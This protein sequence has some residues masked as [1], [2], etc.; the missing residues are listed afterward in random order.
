[1]TTF[2]T[3]CS[4]IESASVA[5]EPLGFTAQWFSEIEAFP[6]AVLHH[7]WPH[8]P[9]IGDM[10]HIAGMVR[11]GMVPAPEVF[12]AGTPCQSF[13]VAGLRE[14]IEDP[15][16]QLTLEYVRV[17]DAID[18]RRGAN[19]ECVAV[20]ENVPG[21]LTSKDNAFGEFLA[22]LCGESEGLVP[23]GKGWT[24]AGYV[25]GP[26]RAIAWRTLDAQYFGVAQRR[27]RV[28]LV[29][30]ARPDFD[31]AAVLFESEGVRRDTPPR[32]KH[33][34]AGHTPDTALRPFDMLGFGQY[35]GGLTAS[36]LKARDYKDWTDLVIERGRVRG[37]TPSERERLQGF[38]EGHTAVPYRNKPASE[39]PDGPRYKAIGNSKAVPVIRWVG[40]RIKAELT[41]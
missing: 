26:E 36:T 29:A 41:K 33:G 40:E 17:I 35:G 34:E 21:V 15:R 16:G 25:F 12:I 20:W 23:T 22:A 11:A 3:A 7:H 14:G 9:N 10:G 6:C 27:K 1:M 19:N 18:E 24:R 5:L 31:P 37:V 8:V 38:P 2:A 13:S 32:H 39:C 4:G 30:S 28:F